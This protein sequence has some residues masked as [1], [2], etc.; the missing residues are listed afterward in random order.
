MTTT[1]VKLLT[2]VHCSLYASYTDSCTSPACRAVQ[3]SSHY[4]VP[5]PAG[6]VG[7]YPATSGFGR[8]S[9]I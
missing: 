2:S 9:K 1:Q 4:P 7:G 8:I 6:Y 5:I 3:Q